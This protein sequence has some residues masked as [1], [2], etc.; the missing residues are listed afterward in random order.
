MPAYPG[1]GIAMKV[2]PRRFLSEEDLD[3]ATLSDEDFARLSQQARLAA[4][5]TND[6]D[7]HVYRHGCLAVEPGYEHLLPLI[8]TGAL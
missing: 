5:S 6:L 3:L 4:Q 8:R 7:A 1:G 2:D